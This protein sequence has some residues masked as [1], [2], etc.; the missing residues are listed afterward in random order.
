MSK[1]ARPGTWPGSNSTST[2]TSLSGAK[3][4]RNTDPKSRQAL[5]VVA[6]AEVGEDLSVDGDLDCHE[7]SV[8][9]SW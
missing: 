2:S 6:P 9:D 7:G 3:S 5:D 8:A 1:N 4:S